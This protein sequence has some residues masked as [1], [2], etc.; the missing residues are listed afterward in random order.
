MLCLG[1]YPTPDYR[2]CQDGIVLIGNQGGT[3]QAPTADLVPI[4]IL[5]DERP[6]R[7]GIERGRQGIFLQRPDGVPAGRIR[8]RFP[9]PVI[10]DGHSSRHLSHIQ[11]VGRMPVR[12]STDRV[13]DPT[14]L[15]QIL[16][17]TR[18]PVHVRAGENV[19]QGFVAHPQESPAR[20][21]KL[22]FRQ[23][24]VRGIPVGIRGKRGM[25]GGKV[26]VRSALHLHAQPRELL[27][28]DEKTP[29]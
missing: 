13:H 20:F 1:F 7:S 5:Q 29:S 9:E 10:A 15:V 26:P 11:E 18:E 27:V 6:G 23:A 12:K 4:I 3:D 21:I 28:T 25:H 22:V 16:F 2:P 14:D 17:L 8:Q 24:G 19:T